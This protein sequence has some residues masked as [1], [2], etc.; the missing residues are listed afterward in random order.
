MTP[1]SVSLL[2]R[3][4]VARPDATDWCRVQEKIDVYLDQLAADGDLASEWDSEHDRHVLLLAIVRPD[5]Q[6]TT[7]DAFQRFAIEGRPAADVAAE[8]GLNVNSVL[9]AKSR[10]LKRLREEAGDILK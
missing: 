2:D 7:W 3:L 10:I 9:Q 5:F 8:L 6:P 4:R 1:T